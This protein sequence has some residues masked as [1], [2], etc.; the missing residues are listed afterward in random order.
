VIEAEVARMIPILERRLDRELDLAGVMGASSRH[1]R[2][3]RS[4]SPL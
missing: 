3:G 1:R 4:R 2:P